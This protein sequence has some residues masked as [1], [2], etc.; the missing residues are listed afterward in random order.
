MLVAVLSR[1]SVLALSRVPLVVIALDPLRRL[2]KLFMQPMLA[3]SP[4]PA[5]VDRP[6]ELP[7]SLL[8]KLLVVLAQCPELSTFPAA[9]LRVI[10]RTLLSILPT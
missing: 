7:T 3:I 9:E 4:R 10:T 5:I 8:L 2:T 6:I 1:P